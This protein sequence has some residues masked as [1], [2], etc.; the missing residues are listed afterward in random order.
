MYYL[1]CVSS[2]VCY[3]QQLVF[4]DVDFVKV[5]ISTVSVTIHLCILQVRES[6]QE[7]RS[8]M[9][10]SAIQFLPFSNCNCSQS[11]PLLCFRSEMLRSDSDRHLPGL[12]WLQKLSY[13]VGHVLN[14]LCASMW[15]SY[16]LLYF[17]S[18][19]LFSKPMAGY[20]LLLG[21][22]A[23]AIATPLV[24]YES[25]RLNGFFGYGKRKS[26]HALGTLN[27]FLFHVGC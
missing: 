22:V 7:Y 18:V 11:A 25:D 21:Q 23:D 3:D 2:F 17:E 6:Q 20:V 13:G 12:P 8:V 15:F 14:D 26:W 9:K 24:G 16:L 10:S 27:G 1:I 4:Y 19:N 5:V